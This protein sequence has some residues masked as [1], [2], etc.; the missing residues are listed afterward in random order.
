MYLLYIKNGD[1]EWF[2]LENYKSTLEVALIEIS[3]IKED[4]P[5][6]TYRLEEIT[7]I[8]NKLI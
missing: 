8:G 6:E 2:F 3:K 5:N 4:N 7:E 1:D